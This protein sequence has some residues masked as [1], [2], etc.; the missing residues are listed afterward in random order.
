MLTAWAQA[1]GKEDLSRL[2]LGFF[3]GIQSDMLHTHREIGFYSKN[4][5]MLK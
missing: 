4:P 2:Y 1:N 3:S 5:V